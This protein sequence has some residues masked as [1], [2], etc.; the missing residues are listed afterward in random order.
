VSDLVEK[1]DKNLGGRYQVVSRAHTERLIKNDKRSVWSVT[2][3]NNDGH[4]HSIT[5][6][7][8]SLWEQYPFGDEV[9][10]AF[11]LDKQRKLA[12]HQVREKT[13]EEKTSDEK[14]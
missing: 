11:G 5:S 12:V 3:R 10:L 8:P 9:K 4:T 1:S 14:E 13:G 6:K 2:L 7:S